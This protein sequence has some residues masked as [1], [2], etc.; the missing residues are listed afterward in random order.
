MYCPCLCF[1]SIR[2]AMRSSS[3][4]SKAMIKVVLVARSGYLGSR[5]NQPG[6]HE[7]AI[8]VLGGLVNVEDSNSLAELFVSWVDGDPAATAEFEELIASNLDANVE[9]MG[10]QRKPAIRAQ[11]QPSNTS[12]AAEEPELVPTNG[13]GLAL[14]REIRDGRYLHDRGGMAG[15]AG[16][17][18]RPR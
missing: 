16:P 9:A 1:P 18:L 10:E 7:M 12:A 14:R 6:M 4:A 15:R 17:T 2:R 13:E 8:F 3:S 11:P 5:F